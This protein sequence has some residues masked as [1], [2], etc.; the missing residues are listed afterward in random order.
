[1]EEPGWL[2]FYTAAREVEQ[3]RAVSQA[4]AQA[5]LRQACR[6]EKMRSMKAPHKGEQDQLPFGLW[7]R[8]APRNWRERD[9]DYDGPNADGYWTIVMISEADFQH[10]LHQEATTNP[11]KPLGGHQPLLIR[12]LTE[13]FLDRPVPDK[14][15]YKHEALLE[16]LRK[17]HKRLAKLDQATL[18][19]AIKSYNSTF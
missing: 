7:T 9:V 5:M 8:L 4:E 10:W 18:A 14:S 3:R 1:M 11:E 2:T 15:E 17:T 19:T 13:K 12:L 6:D 16:E